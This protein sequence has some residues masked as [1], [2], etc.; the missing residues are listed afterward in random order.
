M[1]SIVLGLN[2]LNH[3]L[4]QLLG[5]TVAVTVQ[6]QS[7]ASYL[8]MNKLIPPKHRWKTEKKQHDIFVAIYQQPICFIMKSINLFECVRYIEN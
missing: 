8:Y 1:A 5:Y 6:S 2:V 3:M 7:T 4:Y